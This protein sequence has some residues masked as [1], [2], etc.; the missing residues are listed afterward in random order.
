MKRLKLLV[1]LA[2]PGP[3]YKNTRHNVGAWFI[4][5]IINEK[6]KTFKFEKKFQGNYSKISVLGHDIH[7]I[8]PQTYMNLSGQS[9]LAIMNF[10]KIKAEETLVAHD[11][12]DLIPGVAKI[13]LGGGHG[14]HNGLK[15][16]MSRISSRDFLRLRIGIGHPGNRNFVSKYVLQSPNLEDRTKIK[17]SIDNSLNVLEHIVEYQITK[18]QNTLHSQNK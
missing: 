18:A 10:F 14:G 8:V 1:G 3:E 5:S 17:V 4:E 9:V 11:D 13:K 6:N 2:N 16:I 12:L 15:D 7:V